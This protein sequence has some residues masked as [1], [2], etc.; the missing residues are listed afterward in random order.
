MMKTGAPFTQVAAFVRRWSAGRERGPGEARSSQPFTVS[1]LRLRGGLSIVLLIAGLSMFAGVGEA[2]AA[3]ISHVTDTS[4]GEQVVRFFS[5]RD[6]LLRTAVIGC[7]LMGISSG[8][9]GGFMVVRR[10]ALIGDTISHAVLPGIMMGYLWH[11][12]KDPVALFVG[13][14]IAG[15]LGSVFVSMIRQTTRIKQDAALGIV[16]GGFYALGIL[17]KSI[18][19]RGAGGDQSGLDDFLFG[20]AAALSSGDVILMAVVTGLALLLVG[21]FYRQFFV[22][23]F[24]ET[25]AESLG[26]PSQVFHYLLMVL[27]AFAIVVALQAVGAVLVSAMLIIPPATA[28][29]LT[30]RLHK[31]LLLSVVI[32]VVASVGGAF[33]SFLSTGLPTGPFMIVSAAAC[34]VM[35]FLFSPSHGVLPRVMRRREQT[36]RIQ[37]E[38]TLK[39]MYHLIEEAEGDTGQRRHRV[40]VESLMTKR[41]RDTAEFDAEIAALV[42]HDLARRENG[43]I[44]LTETGWTRAQEIV[45]NHRLWELYLT[46]AA[47][48]A[49]DHVHDDA[50][51]IE[52]VIGAELVAELEKQLKNARIDP[53]G[54]NIPVVEEGI[55][56]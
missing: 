29:L 48:I 36:K 15:V 28:Y 11:L 25:F 4:I 2:H 54:S 37:R 32:G 22:S 16:L 35:A 27:L 18:I 6:P 31:L 42:R 30:D 23:S 47:D 26:V 13:A 41:G 24:D 7:I 56:Q 12:E 53:H 20:N 8:L 17:I 45:R 50:E 21:I 1:P 19:Q 3:R 34:F 46:N 9:L 38:N 33:F 43:S 39:A 14:V 5:M 52:H 44:E 10:L 55:A 49:S 51:I 40:S